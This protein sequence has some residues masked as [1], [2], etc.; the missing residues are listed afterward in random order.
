MPTRWRTGAGCGSPSSPSACRS[1]PARARSLRRDTSPGAAS[2]TASGSPTMSRWRPACPPT[3]PRSPGTRR[4][5]AA[6]SPPCPPRRRRA[7]SPPS[8]RPASRRRLS[9][10]SRRAPA[11][12][13]WRSAERSAAPR[14]LHLLEAPRPVALEEPGERAVGEQHAARLAARAVVGLVLGVDDALHG[15]AAVGTGLAVA[16]MDGHAVAEGGHLL[17]EAV[18]RLR[19]QAFGPFLQR[20]SR[21]GEEASALVVVELARQ[22]DRREAGSVQ[23]L[24]GVSVADAGEQAGVG[25]RALQGVILARQGGAEA[26][27]VGLEDLQP[28]RVEGGER[29]GAPGQVERGPLAR[30]GRGP[31]ARA[32]G[33]VERRDAEPPGDAPAR[34]A[35]VE[36]ARDHQVEDQ[37]ELLLAAD[38]EALAEPAEPG[39]PPPFGGREGRLQ[40]AKEERAPEPHALE[41]LREDARPQALEVDDDV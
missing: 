11:A 33:E 3:W 9:A 41:P 29:A 21:G 18:A 37:E 34:R 16:P 26:R 6:S 40:R 15:R 31:E 1:C 36:A 10:A 28:A 22:L 30:P 20:G 23:D 27:Q 5:R 19:A 32:G 17:G 2:A 24:V 4:P 7:S 13:G 12:P 35:P 14:R 39:H 25:E 8:R 38:H